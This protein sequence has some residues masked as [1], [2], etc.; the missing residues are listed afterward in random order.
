MAGNSNYT[1]G[2]NY[3]AYYNVNYNTNNGET[4][5]DASYNTSSEYSSYSYQTNPSAACIYTYQGYGYS[6]GYYSSP[7]YSTGEYYA[8]YASSLEVYKKH[9]KIKQKELEKMR[10]K[11]RRNKGK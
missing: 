7:T 6:Y 2:S 10:R 8:C 11:E 3:A 1:Y 9:E 5:V 4:S